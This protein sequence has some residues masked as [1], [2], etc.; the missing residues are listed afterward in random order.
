M[1]HNAP[2]LR[3]RRPAHAFTLIET[4]LAIALAALIALSV[5]GM[6]FSA[7]RA[8][9]AEAETQDD[10]VAKQLAEPRLAAPIREAAKILA[11][12][13]D[14]LVLWLGDTTDDGLVN[15]SELRVLAYNEGLEHVLVYDAVPGVSPDTGYDPDE[16]F[17]AVASAAVGAGSLEGRVIITGVSAWTITLDEA[18]PTDARVVSVVVTRSGSAGAQEITAVASPRATV[19]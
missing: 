1:T 9:A 16:D 15:V 7:S 19:P 5:V 2:G 18:T 4:L 6:L 10:V 11:S 12:D 13:D 3:D 17:L 8:I 14:R